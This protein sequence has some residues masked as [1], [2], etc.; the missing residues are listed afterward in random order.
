MS[1][2]A[3]SIEST[4]RFAK[5]SQGNEISHAALIGI[6]QVPRLSVFTREKDHIHIQY[7]CIRIYKKCN[8]IATR[9]NAKQRE[10]CS[11]SPA[12]C[13]PAHLKSE[14]TMPLL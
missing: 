10:V 2:L 14:I 4:V 13:D 11:E 6:I 8:T 7:I 5:T 3:T 12:T 9:T 1:S